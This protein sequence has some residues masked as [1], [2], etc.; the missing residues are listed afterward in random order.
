MFLVFWGVGEKQLGASDRSGTMLAMGL[1]TAGVGIGGVAICGHWN[2]YYDLSTKYGPH[3][4]GIGTT[5]A[6]IPGMITNIVSGEI[7]DMLD[8]DPSAT[9]GAATSTS[10]SI[11]FW[12]QRVFL[13]SCP[14]LSPCR[15]HTSRDVLYLVPMFAHVYWV[16]IGAC[17]IR[18]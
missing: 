8:R 4:L 5:I 1:L 13:S 7:L 11:S 9:G 18:C 10:S 3:L 2:N 16:L 12:D 17:A 14:S 6:T 15:P